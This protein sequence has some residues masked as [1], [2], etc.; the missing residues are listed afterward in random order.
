MTWFRCHGIFFQYCVLLIQFEKKDKQ[1][2]SSLLE[3]LVSI[4]ST[5]L[6]TFSTACAIQL[7][8]LT[9]RRTD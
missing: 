3:S 6:F 5:R 1:Y 8:A 4:L 2:Q 7:L 9:N